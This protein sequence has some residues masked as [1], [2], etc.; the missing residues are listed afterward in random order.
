ML[1][2]DKPTKRIGVGG[3]TS[4]P[5]ATKPL[6]KIAPSSTSSSSTTKIPLSRDL[7]SKLCSPAAAGLSAGVTLQSAKPTLNSVTSR[8]SVGHMHHMKVGCG[9]DSSPT[10][11]TAHKSTIASQ[12]G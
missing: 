1:C 9:S 8:R 12:S 11:V 10:L 6:R 3:Q 2:I 4:N 7:S 5:S